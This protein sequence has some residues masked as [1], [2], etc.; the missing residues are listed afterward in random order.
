MPQIAVLIITALIQYGPSAALAIKA[1]L[2]KTEP[3]QADW[4][5]VFNL[6]TQQKYD[7]YIAAAQAKAGN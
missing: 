1:I 5:A 3:T 2:S 7:D 4:D 6:A